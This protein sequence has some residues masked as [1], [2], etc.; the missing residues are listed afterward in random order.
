MIQ[1]SEISN[2]YNVVLE[3]KDNIR[4]R[5]FI[6]DYDDTI[7]IKDTYIRTREFED[8]SK[9]LV[10]D[11]QQR[12]QTLFIG[13]KGTY[14]KNELYFNVLSG[15]EHDDEEFRFHFDYFSIEDA[16][17]KSGEIEYWYLFKKIVFS[18]DAAATMRR[19]IISEMETNGVTISDKMEN[20]IDINVSNIIHLFSTEE[21]IQYYPIDREEIP[22][23]EILEI[24][25]RTNS[26]GTPLSKSDLMFS[27]I[28]LNWEDAEEAFETLL[29]KINKQGAFKFDIDF[30]LKS[31]LVLTDKKSKICGK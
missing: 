2:R 13:L 19:N 7:L 23:E 22:Y 6:D 11:G 24:F 27:L 12:L 3:T 31:S 4:M 25:I 26:G 20:T 21:L 29:N 30:L 15:D 9:I 14:K 1:F 17:V 8:K 10:L 18:R 16:K 28:K 5:K